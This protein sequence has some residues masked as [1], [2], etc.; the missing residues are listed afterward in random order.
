MDRHDPRRRYANMV[1]DA[2]LFVRKQ[3]IGQQLTPRESQRLGRMPE[4]VQ[5][6]I[7]ACKPKDSRSPR[8]DNSQK[9]PRLL[10]TDL[11]KHAWG[12]KAVIEAIARHAGCR[13]TTLYV[14]AQDLA[15]GTLQ[16]QSVWRPKED[17]PPAPP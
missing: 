14:W 13:P 2:R 5:H 15:Q 7:N 12:F 9:K 10:R 6:A 4:E 1:L 17:P 3:A 16:R 11:P 8:L